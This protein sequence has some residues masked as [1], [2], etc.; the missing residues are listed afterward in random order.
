FS[1]TDSMDQV[2]SGPITL[3]FGGPFLF[4]MPN[5]EW[6]KPESAVKA[7]NGWVRTYKFIARTANKA[8]VLPFQ[9][10]SPNTYCSEFSVATIIDNSKK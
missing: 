5:V 4:P 7:G 3:Y 6:Q 8:I 1:R 2:L 10:N 9:D